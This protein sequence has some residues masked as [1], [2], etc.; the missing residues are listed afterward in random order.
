MNRLINKFF[1]LIG[2]TLLFNACKKEETP[3]GTY[4]AGTFILNEGRF[5]TSSGTLSFLSEDE[6]TLSNEVFQNVNDRPLGNILQSMTIF[7]ERAYFVINNAQKVEVAEAGELLSVGSITGLDQ[8]R[9]FLGID[10]D[11]AYISQWGSTG[12]NGSIEIVDLSTLLV[13]NSIATSGGPETMI[14]RNGKVYVAVSGGFSSDN[15]VLVIN[16][17]TDAVESSITVGDNPNSM[18]IGANGD[19]WVLCSGNKVYNPDFTLN[20]A[21][22]SAGSMHR[23]DLSNN[24][25]IW[26]QSFSDVSMSPSKLQATPDLN[27]FYFLANGVRAFDVSSPSLSGSALIDGFYYGLGFHPIT[28]ELYVA[29]AVDFVSS[30]KVYRYSETGTARDT[31]NVGIIP[32]GFFFK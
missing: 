17:T 18:Q 1:L 13:V 7:E 9:Y 6:T 5:N 32:N 8:P 28:R 4:D 26:S 25:V 10:E 30:G 24:S 19:L 2:I 23:I 29:D 20:E 14:L 22:S 16:P 15:R 3:P 31:L 21:A 27:T 12:S 11:K